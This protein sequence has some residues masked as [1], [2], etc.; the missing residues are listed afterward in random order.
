MGHPVSPDAWY[1]TACQLRR[2]SVYSHRSL[3]QQK[4]MKLKLT[5]ISIEKMYNIFNIYINIYGY[6]MYPDPFV[7]LDPWFQELGL[8]PNQCS[9]NRK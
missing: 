1:C 2:I 6:R 8:D 5:K 7:D 3:T 9:I 4:K